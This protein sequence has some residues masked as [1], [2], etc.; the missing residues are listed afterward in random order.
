LLSG[1][2]PHWVKLSR[3]GSIITASRRTDGGSWQTIGSTTI[4]MPT[5]VYV[6]VAVTSHDATRPADAVVGSIKIY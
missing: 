3:R 4:A 6:G 5:S 1:T 2:A